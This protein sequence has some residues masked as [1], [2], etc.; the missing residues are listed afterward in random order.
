MSSGEAPFPAFPAELGNATHQYRQAQIAQAALPEAVG[1]AA[2]LQVLIAASCAAANRIRVTYMH[3]TTASRPHP[4]LGC[5]PKC[6]W[7][8]GRDGEL[9][10][11]TGRL[12][13]WSYAGYMAGD[14]LIPDFGAAIFSVKDYGAKG[15]G[16]TGGWEG[17]GSRR[18][19]GYPVQVLNR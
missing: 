14:K 9:W 19:Q 2:G 4:V 8:W 18:Q 11:P 10:R 13:D 3:C 5:P 7:L 15:D 12:A 16:Q 6:S 1:G 17:E